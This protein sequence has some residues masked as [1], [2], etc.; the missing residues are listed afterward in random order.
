MILVAWVIGINSTITQFLAP[1]PYSFSERA[2]ALS[3]F[4]PMIG[5]VV[6]EFWSNW[7]QDYL[8]N[9][10]IRRH[11]GSFNLE[12]RLWGCYPA[13]LVCFVGLVLFGQAVQHQLHWIVLL[14]A[15]GFVSFSM[16]SAVG[17][18]STYAIDTF[19]HHA[20]LV[21][22]IINFWRTAG[23]FCVV[24][25]QLK[26]VALSGPGIVFGCQAMILGVGF[27][28]GVVLVQFMGK[29]WRYV[30][31]HIISWS[32]RHFLILTIVLPGQ[33][34]P[35][36]QRRTKR[37]MSLVRLMQQPRL[38]ATV[39]AAFLN[40]RYLSLFFPRHRIPG[41]HDG[42]GLTDLMGREDQ[43]VY[44]NNLR[45]SENE[46]FSISQVHPS[47]LKSGRSIVRR[48]HLLSIMSCFAFGI[49]IGHSNCR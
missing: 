17:V 18:V 45:F 44:Y 14:I 43:F 8:S 20:A 3:Y 39:P 36:R 7:L 13:A 9:S 11:A 24:Y 6:G 35:P 16:M 40:S 25:F 15:W 37:A 26:W 47:S 21:G 41:H 4:A 33:S 27:L 12:H 31:R 32:I 34:T 22:A 48:V 38:Y 5:S 10:Y 19:P 2:I 29:R 30:R 23:G 28:V 49:D 42:Y 1:P 46:P